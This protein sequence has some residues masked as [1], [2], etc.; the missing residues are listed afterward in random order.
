MN[1]LIDQEKFQA[2]LRRLISHVMFKG[3]CFYWNE[4]MLF[5]SNLYYT[6]NNVRSPR[7]TVMQINEQIKD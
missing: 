1:L 6:D 4:T 2:N 7:I 3:S 5:K